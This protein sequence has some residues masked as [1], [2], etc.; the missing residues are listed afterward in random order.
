M[1]LLRILAAVFV[2][3]PAA[4]A[5]AEA[6]GPRPAHPDIVANDIASPRA[7]PNRPASPSRSSPG[8]DGGI[9]TVLARSVRR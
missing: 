8:A 7:R 1:L 6:G 4:L 3:L 2:L 9:P 5:R